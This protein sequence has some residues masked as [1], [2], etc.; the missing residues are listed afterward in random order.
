MQD[1]N[2]F[3]VILLGTNLVNSILS[4]ACSWANLKVLHIDEN[5][6]Y[7][8]VDGSFSL[9][10]IINISENGN[11]EVGNLRIKRS[12]DDALALQDVNIEVLE[13]GLLPSFKGF[14]IELISKEMYAGGSLVELLSKTKIYKYLL[15]KPQR[16]FRLYTSDQVWTKVPESRADIFNDKTLPLTHKRMIMRFMKFVSSVDDNQNQEK[17]KEWLSKPFQDFLKK[18]FELPRTIQEGIVYG[19]CQSLDSN[20]STQHALEKIKKYYQSFGTYGE[21]SYLLAMY[22]TGSELCQGFCRS[23]AVMGSTFMLAQK[24]NKVEATSVELGEGERVWANN[25]ITS[26]PMKSASK[27]GINIRQRCII[28]RGKCPGL[29]HQN[30]FLLSEASQI[31]FVPYSLGD[32]FSNSVQVRAL[33]AGTGNCPEGYTLWYL[34]TLDCEEYF[35]VFTLATNKLLE[36]SHSEDTKPLMYVDVLIDQNDLA[37]YDVA[38]EIAKQLYETI[39]GSTDT[40]FQ[41][42]TSFDD[43]DE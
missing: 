34:Q 23:S 9:R 20:I 19:L 25:V 32:R 11:L 12:G 39:T 37:D 15:L 24:I 35:E 16:S 38:V 18:N 21:Y 17:L 14:T 41:R 40:F 13:K 4:S 36:L 6:F 28:V 3:D 22:G 8:E 5:P 1:S 43:D 42:D 10:D 2:S 30:L 33:G 31:H 7:G 29:F 26:R 27:S